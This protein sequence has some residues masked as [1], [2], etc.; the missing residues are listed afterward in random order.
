V[1]NVV[2]KSLDLVEVSQVRL[3]ELKLYKYYDLR[4]IIS[5]RAY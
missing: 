2:L 3:S 1:M 5:I 4:N